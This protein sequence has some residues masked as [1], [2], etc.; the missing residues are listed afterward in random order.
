MHV[1]VELPESGVKTYEFQLVPRGTVRKPLS[2]RIA[3]ADGTTTS[4]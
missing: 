3:S 1:S 2:V 4:I